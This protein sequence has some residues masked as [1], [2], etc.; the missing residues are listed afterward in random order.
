[1]FRR[2]TAA[3]IVATLAA[4]GM[5]AAQGPAPAGAGST[6]FMTEQPM[7]MLRASKFIGLGVYG[8]GNQKIGDINEIL[9]DGTGAAKA[10][11]IGVG[12]FLGIAEKGVA[13]PFS[14]LTWVNTRPAPTS[15]AG[16]GIMSSTMAG[17]TSAAT[18]VGNMASSVTGTSMSAAARNPDEMAA[19][20]GY[21]DH[22]TVPLTKADLQNAPQFKY[23]FETHPLTAAPL[24]IAPTSPAAKP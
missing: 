7:G 9:I 5:A 11:V 16:T 2:R 13:I 18:S 1:M 24:N 10:A 23:Y 4:A 8:V 20:N 6:A 17:A 12:G 14:A 3:F 19:Y 15:D 22:A 21:P